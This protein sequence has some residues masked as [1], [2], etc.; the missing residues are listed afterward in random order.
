Y[1]DGTGQTPAALRHLGI[2][3]GRVATVSAAP[4]DETGCPKVIA[5]TGRW[6]TP[7]FID[8][9]THYDAEILAAPGLS[10]SVRHGVTT[11]MVG[12]CSLSMVCSDAE[13]ASDIFTRVETVPREKVLPLLHEKKTWS[14]PAEW[15][16]F[17]RQ[18]PLG[19][20]V[21]S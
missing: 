6:I 8:M 10:E 5:A 7:G 14:T 17:V 16:R 12:S 4:L 21:M 1:F 15:V 13:D 20:N 9:H 18:Q 11:V 3:D 19:P 2:R